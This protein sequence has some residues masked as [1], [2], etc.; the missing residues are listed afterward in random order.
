MRIIPLTRGNETIVDDDDYERL[1]KYSWAWVPST[2]SLS[3]EG[4]AVRKGNKK[5]GEPRTVQ[6]HREILNAPKDRAVDHINIHSLDNR[7]ENLRYADKQQN[8]F[9]RRKIAV[10]CT[11]CYKGVFRRSKPRNLDKPWT[12]RIRF[13]GRRIELGVY[14]DEKT[15]AAAYNLA[16]RIFFGD[17]RHENRKVYELGQPLMGVLLE[18]IKRY[19]DRYGWRVD[20]EAYHF[21]YDN[22]SKVKIITFPYLQE[23]DDEV[24]SCDASV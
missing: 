1:M 19:I 21:F 24:A 18:R 4:Y 23:G 17:F 13:N 10:S 6:M 14:E 20:T 15:A 9:N 22:S 2:S 11:S 12:S 7:K 3:G 16:S 8:A 5:K